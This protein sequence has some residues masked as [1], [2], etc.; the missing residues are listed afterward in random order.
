MTTRH[1]IRSLTHDELDAVS[2]GRIAL[3]TA[4]NPDAG[5]PGAL[6]RT[7]NAGAGDAL[8]T[9]LG[10]GIAGFILAGALGAL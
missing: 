10:M 1:E 9:F 8:A 5:G 6:P 3:H 7:G 4:D 2:G